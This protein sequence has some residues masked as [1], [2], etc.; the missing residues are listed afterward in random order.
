MKALDYVINPDFSME[1]ECLENGTLTIEDVRSNVAAVLL[2]AGLVEAAEAAQ[3]STTEE[4]LME[5]M[6]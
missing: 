1:L 3:S 4:D 6:L 2:D 5:V